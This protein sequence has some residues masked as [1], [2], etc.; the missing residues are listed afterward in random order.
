MTEER[1]PFRS[2]VIRPLGAQRTASTDGLGRREFDFL[3]RNWVTLPAGHV[4]PRCFGANEASAA[5]VQT[6]RLFRSLDVTR[7]ALRS[8]RWFYSNDGLYLV[9]VAAMKDTGVCTLD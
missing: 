7:H 9:N 5:D 8:P 3:M 6:R 1:K 2:S 4:S